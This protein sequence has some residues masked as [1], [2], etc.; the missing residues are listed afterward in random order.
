ME[1]SLART[2]HDHVTNN[3]LCLFNNFVPA[4]LLRRCGQHIVITSS[5][6]SISPH[7]AHDNFGRIGGQRTQCM[8]VI[9]RSRE[10]L[11][12][13]CVLSHFG[14]VTV[15][16]VLPASADAQLPPTY[17]HVF[18]NLSDTDDWGA[19][20]IRMLNNDTKTD[21]MQFAR[22]PLLMKMLNRRSNEI[23][24]HE[25]VHQLFHSGQR[26]DLFVLGFNFNDPLLGIAA[27][28]R[29]PSVILTPTPAL[30]MIRDFV[31][32]PAEIA[33]T[34]I[35]GKHGVTEVPPK[36][37]SRFLL[38]IGYTIEYAV[39]SIANNFI[40]EPLYANHFPSAKGY[41]TYDEIKRNVSL[42]LVNHHF[43]QGDF[44]PLYPN[45]VDIGGIQIR[46]KPKPMPTVSVKTID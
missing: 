8:I 4:Q 35:F 13:F 21:L 6:Q 40:H 5:V 23:L 33:T 11:F 41:P 3:L 34:P 44:R 32:N 28:F 36:F 38:F 24:R 17:H 7:N 43:S 10:L 25:I 2:N 29:C 20:R 45:I 16:S 42:V 37:L 27:H 39:I 46:A 26:F 30:K 15:F 14:Q 22:I 1:V 12:S 19:F 18:L 31:G 9:A